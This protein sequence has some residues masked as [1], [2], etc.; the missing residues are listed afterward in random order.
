MVSKLNTNSSQRNWVLFVNTIYMHMQC[1]IHAVNY[2]HGIPFTI[3]KFH[4]FIFKY[5][6]LGSSTDFFIFFRV[7]L[8]PSYNPQKNIVKLYHA[9]ELVPHQ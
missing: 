5:S 8:D 9:F 7:I 6:A 3:R 2:V 1:K 4:I